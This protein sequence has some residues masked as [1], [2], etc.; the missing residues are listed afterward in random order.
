M[1]PYASQPYSARAEGGRQAPGPATPAAAGPAL[2][3]A[4]GS[5]ASL[6][7][8]ARVLADW[9]GGGSLYSGRVTAVD[10]HTGCYS[11]VYDDGDA[12]SGVPPARVR[13]ATLALAGGAG[14]GVVADGAVADGRPMTTATTAAGAV[15]R[16]ISLLSERIVAMELVAES[17]RTAASARAE[18]TL[19]AVAERAAVAQALAS[20]E[21]RAALEA[22]EARQREALAASEGRQREQRAEDE[23]RLRETLGALVADSVAKA[24]DGGGA[25]GFGGGRG[26]RSALH[27]RSA[28]LLAPPLQEGRISAGDMSTVRTPRGTRLYHSGS[29]GSLDEMRERRD[30]LRR[31]LATLLSAEIFSAN[32]REDE[33]AAAEGPR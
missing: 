1:Q 5:D 4:L 31:R 8:G 22:A 30:L 11:I 24:V 21:V 27:A 13:P 28:G 26:V 9:R 2:P 12:E 14:G 10:G 17:E 32:P 3:V 7:V 18:A 20:V 19:V 33:F 25:G 23:R 16:E 15:S 29:H 6:A